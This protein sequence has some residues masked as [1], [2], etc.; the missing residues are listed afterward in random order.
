M[1]DEAAKGERQWV[2]HHTNWT[3]SDG[4]LSPEGAWY[5]FDSPDDQQYLVNRLNDYRIR[6]VIE[7]EVN[8]PAL[9]RLEAEAAKARRW[10]ELA[11]EVMV[12][13]HANTHMTFDADGQ[14]IDFEDCS[15]WSCK[16]NRQRLADYDAAL[17]DS[18]TIE[19]KEQRYREAL[20]RIANDPSP[21]GTPQALIRSMRS[22]ARAALADEGEVKHAP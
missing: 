10:R 7:E 13:F 8:I 15:L 17:A 20:K 11:R 1:N 14:P 22:I 9:Q 12:D 4:V 6:R 21:L 5:N 2:L 16:Y 18:P 19:S 3:D